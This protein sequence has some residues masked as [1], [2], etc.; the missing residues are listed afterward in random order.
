MLSLDGEK[1]TMN[2]LKVR[3]SKEFKEQDLSGQSSST[4]RAEQGDKGVEVSVSG[5]I[6]FKDEEQLTRLY[7]LFGAKDENGD[8]KVYRI[9]NRDTRLY[10]VREVKF[11]GRL[12][13]EEHDTLQGWVI[14]FSMRENLSAAEKQEVREREQNQ[15]N[16]QDHDA[17]RQQLLK[18]QEVLGNETE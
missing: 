9:S 16:Q 1:L 4:F 18:T 5:I 12:S 14:G 2:N 15:P 7:E 3:C 13:S 6:P 8:R 17:H 11:T 10:R